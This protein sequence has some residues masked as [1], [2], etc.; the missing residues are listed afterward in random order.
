MTKNEKFDIFFM[1][2]LLFLRYLLPKISVDLS[3]NYPSSPPVEEAWSEGLERAAVLLP[4]R[5]LS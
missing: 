3:K 1:V 2:S 5:P 4:R